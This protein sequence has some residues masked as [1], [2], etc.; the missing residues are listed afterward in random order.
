MM[1]NPPSP[2][3]SNDLFERPEWNGEVARCQPSSAAQPVKIPTTF[4]SDAVSRQARAVMR[5]TMRA[6]NRVCHV[7]S[8][9][10]DARERLS[11]RGGGADE[12]RQV[13]GMEARDS[14]SVQ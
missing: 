8:S 5:L 14:A 12:K 7:C 2:L 13:S 1:R 10:S 4:V 11:G 3:A 9:I 6:A